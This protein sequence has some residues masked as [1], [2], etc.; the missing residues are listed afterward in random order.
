MINV[1]SES[2]V[3]VRFLDCVVDVYNVLVIHGLV[4]QKTLP[5]SVLKVQHFFKTIAYT[6]GGFLFTPD[7]IEHGVLRGMAHHHF[8]H[9]PFFRG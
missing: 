8:T 6:I 9:I 3:L 4:E 1:G 2:T 5:D 7:D